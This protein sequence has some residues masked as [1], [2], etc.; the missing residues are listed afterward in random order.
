MRSFSWLRA[1]NTTN[2]ANVVYGKSFKFLIPE[3]FG[4]GSIKDK[5]Q[6]YGKLAYKETGEPKY[7]M[8]ELLAFW[9]APDKV[10]FNGDFP[11]LKEIDE[12]TEFNRCIGIDIG[13]YD[14]EIDKLEFPLKLVSPSFKGKYKD[15]K[16][17][18]Y[19]DPERGLGERG[20]FV[21]KP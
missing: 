21:R 18:S 10:K 17:P 9:N 12:Y 11:L 19:Y 14:E 8:Y 4:G 16:K 2:V 15:V 1:D 6:G 13:C 5:Y 3:K 7:D 20:L